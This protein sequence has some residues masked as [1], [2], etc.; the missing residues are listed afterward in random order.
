[1]CSQQ[2][3]E[4]I[5][6]NPLE[7]LVFTTASNLDRGCCQ[8]NFEA[9]TNVVNLV[10][11]VENQAKRLDRTDHLWAQSRLLAKLLPDLLLNLLAV[12]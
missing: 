12:Q 2:R 9:T 11:L 8:V 10:S 1:M 5:Q 3:I 6:F 4:L 7:I